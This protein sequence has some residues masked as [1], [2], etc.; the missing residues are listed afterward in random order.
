M[1]SINFLEEAKRGRA[2]LSRQPHFGQTENIICVI[3]TWLRSTNQLRRFYLTSLMFLSHH[4]DAHKA[5]FEIKINAK[6]ESSDKEI[7]E[8]SDE[9][10]E[11]AA[12]MTVLF[13]R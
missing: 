2:K 4:L 7:M 11:N 5:E 13:Q 6:L 8:I 9:Q 3:D 1:T 12:K 10:A